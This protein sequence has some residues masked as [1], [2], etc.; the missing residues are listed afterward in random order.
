MQSQT[1]PYQSPTE[2]ALEV[3]ATELRRTGLGTFWVV[4]WILEGG[5]KASLVV[6]ALWHGFHPLQSLAQEYRA[7]HPLWFFLLLSFFIVET[8]GPWIG[9]YYLTGRRARTI[10]FEAAM[11]RTMLVA[12]GS[13]I[14]AA[15]LL[16]LYCEL[17]APRT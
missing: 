14:G 13:A 5:L 1:N 2:V 9:I 10:A 7:W 17:A 11:M 3:P 15:L 12:C 4:I 8:I 16:M 6:A